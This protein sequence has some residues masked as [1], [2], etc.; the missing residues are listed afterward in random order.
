[1]AA[2]FPQPRG[3]V[4]FTADTL[5]KWHIHPSKVFKHIYFSHPALRKVLVTPVK[6]HQAELD[7]GEEITMRV[8]S[9]ST[10]E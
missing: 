2:L 10:N 8:H 4:T 3:F 6:S 7:T 1:M 5:T 9:K